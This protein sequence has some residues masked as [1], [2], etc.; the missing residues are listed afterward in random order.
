MGSY[1]IEYYPKRNIKD[2]TERRSSNTDHRSVNGGEMIT[3][4]T[5][6]QAAV[7]GPMLQVYL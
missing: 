5:S 2:Q 7:I 4:V 3:M 1:V 6:K